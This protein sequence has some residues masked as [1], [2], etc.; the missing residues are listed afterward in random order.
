MIFATC[1]LGLVGTTSAPAA[2]ATGEIV[3]T[4]NAPGS[5]VSGSPFVVHIELSALGGDVE[6]PAWMLTSSAFAVDGVALGSRDAQAAIPLQDGLSISMDLNLTSLITKSGSF[7]LIYADMTDDK[8]EVT[9][10]TR[11]PNGLDF[12]SMPEGDLSKYNVV[13]QTNRGD[14][15][16]RFFPDLAPGH[17]RN[18]LDLSYSP[19][20]GKPFYEGVIFHRVI[21]GFMIQGGDP[22]GTGS[23]DGKRKLKAE[24]SSKPHKRGILSMARTSDPNSASCQFFVMHA[25]YPSLD[26]QYSV[27]GELVSGIETVDAIVSSPKGAGDRPK[28]K[29]VIEKV[30]VV[31][32]E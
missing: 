6:V 2:I 9:A 24:F 4:I 3:A 10:F 1:L 21:P 14:M 25:D 32:A 28:K 26:N 8:T 17:V 27:F 11:A 20:G 19:D 16:M 13:M 31:M 29:Q 12:M 23:G 15:V 18:F 5:Y 30:M 7:E 22:T